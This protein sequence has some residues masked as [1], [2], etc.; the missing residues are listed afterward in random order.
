MPPR[1]R[2][3]PEKVN[4]EAV[5]E[6]PAESQKKI[7]ARKRKVPE[8]VNDEAIEENPA[9]TP[10]KNDKGERKRKVARKQKSN[11]V[12]TATSPQPTEKHVVVKV[13]FNAQSNEAFH[14]KYV[15]ELTNQYAKVSG[16]VN[17]F[18]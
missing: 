11:E 18:Q 12:E 4:D 16:F 8:K 9:E 6:I 7:P 10:K 1:K 2:K 15:K 3:V 17:P 5:E 14:S 13:L